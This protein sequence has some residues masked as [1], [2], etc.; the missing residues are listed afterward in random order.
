[1]LS[2]E[3]FKVG[4]KKLSTEYSDKG[5]KMTK[6]RVTQWYEYVK[7]MSEIEFNER[8]EYVLKNCSYIPSM[9]DILKSQID[10]TDIKTQEAYATLEYL[11]GAIEFE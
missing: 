5:F 9:A 11:K 8:I 10:N 6:E 3:A 2:K 1:M 4:L 7:N